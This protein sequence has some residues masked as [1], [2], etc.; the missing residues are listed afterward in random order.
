V[1]QTG[2]LWFVTVFP[3][4]TRR[5]S[6][7]G[8]QYRYISTLPNFYEPVDEVPRR[9]RDLGV[10]VYVSISAVESPELGHI[11]RDEG[12]QSVV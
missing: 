2:K 11:L 1:I 6:G 12:L 4:I 7:L 10:F 5:T 9:I 3:R 8:T